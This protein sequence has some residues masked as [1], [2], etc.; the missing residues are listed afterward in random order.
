MI[1]VGMRDFPDIYIYIYIYIYITL[2]STDTVSLV[3]FRS[4]SFGQKFRQVPCVAP[5]VPSGCVYVWDL[6][7]SV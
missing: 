3:I 7:I 2:Y 5:T 4:V 6:K 1:D